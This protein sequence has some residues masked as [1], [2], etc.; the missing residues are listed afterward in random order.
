M[1]NKC[2]QHHT[3]L[4]QPQP[5]ITLWPWLHYFADS[6]LAGS[7]KLA[8]RIS[9]PQPLFFLPYEILHGQMQPQQYQMQIPPAVLPLPQQ[10][11]DPRF[12]QAYAAAGY[13]AAQQQYAQQL[14]QQPQLQMQQQP[15]PVPA[16]PPPPPP[17]RVAAT[18]SPIL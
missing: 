5:S 16:Q 3:V 7:L 8:Q 17:G 14:P 15:A 13:P 18:S 1:S 12:Q 10:Q 11:L 9:T 6:A 4:Q 2:K